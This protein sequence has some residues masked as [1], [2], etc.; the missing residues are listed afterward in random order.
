MRR[1][2]DLFRDI[3]INEYECIH[4]LYSNFRITDSI[5]YQTGVDWR[6]R[7][8]EN[9]LN[10]KELVDKEGA[11]TAYRERLATAEQRLNSVTSEEESDSD[12]ENQAHL[13]RIFRLKQEVSALRQIVYRINRRIIR[14]ENFNTGFDYRVKSQ[15]PE[16]RPWFTE[17][18]GFEIEDGSR[19]VYYP[20]EREN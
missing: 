12:E 20:F 15:A 10:S 6:G 5:P 17:D 8:D 1:V 14:A 2:Q 19:T 9:F 18:T 7:D 3:L 11:I 13:E 16:N 4:R